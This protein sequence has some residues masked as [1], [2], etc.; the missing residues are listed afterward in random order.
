[1]A[2]TDT[3]IKDLVR[4]GWNGKTTHIE[5]EKRFVSPESLG[6]IA[7]FGL[8][9]FSGGS[10][11][12]IL[13]YRAK[14]RTGKSQ[15][16]FKAVRGKDRKKTIGAYPAMTLSRA[17]SEA[18]KLVGEIENGIDPLS[19][20]EPVGLTLEGWAYNYLQ[21]KEDA[22]VR[23]VGEMRR[24]IEKHIV[25]ALGRKRLVDITT[26]DVH[27]LHRKIGQGPNKPHYEANRVKARL[28]DMFTTA[29]KAG[30]LP[31]NFISPTVDVDDYP[32]SPRERVLNSAEAQ[33]LIDAISDIGHQRF[34]ALAWLL[35]TT[36]LRISEARTLKWSDI[37]LDQTIQE[38]SGDKIVER[39][40]PRLTIPA[41][42]SKNKRAHYLPLNQAAVLVLSQIEREADNSFVFAS[43]QRE[44]RP[45]SSQP[46]RRY[47]DQ[48]RKAADLYDGDKRIRWHDLRRTFLT[49]GNAIGHPLHTL[50]RLANQKS[51]S[52]TAGYA[53]VQAEDTRAAAEDISTKLLSDH[54][55]P[56]I[57][58]RT[59]VRDATPHP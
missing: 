2:F 4:K 52:V 44:G 58:T 36:G 13:R 55:E 28:S 19:R 14:E 49:I 50:G 23:S 59:R 16:D 12:W 48:V 53:Q 20:T 31:R 37:E 1:M 33:R 51:L 15:H 3:D 34:E 39:A 46:F 11:R 7:G 29:R 25:P 42:R 38:I 43:T 9:F 8:Q 22:G 18:K 6:F 5:Y 47:W 32:E 57:S 10:I 26:G 54:G 40:A 17:R 27:T 35:I 41:E 45:Y 24:R 30:L 21:E 56:K